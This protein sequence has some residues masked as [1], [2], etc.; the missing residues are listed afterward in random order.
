MN[1]HQL[2]AEKLRLMFLRRLPFDREVITENKHGKW[3]YSSEELATGHAILHVKGIIKEIVPM[4]G[5][6]GERVK[7]ISW[8][9]VLTHL[10]A[11]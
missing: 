6:S 11:M 8:N 10:Q 1:P 4:L 9:L 3:T 7:L 2:K 5:F